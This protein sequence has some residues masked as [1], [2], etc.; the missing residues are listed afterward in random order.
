MGVFHMRK[1]GERKI[2]PLNRFLETGV[3]LRYQL[4]SP[5]GSLLKHGRRDAGRRWLLC[6][7]LFLQ[8]TLLLLPLFLCQEHVRNGHD[9]LCF[10][11]AHHLLLFAAV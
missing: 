4:L 7:L 6:L 5:N 1:G 9:V 2:P 8:P 10:G 11:D 3:R